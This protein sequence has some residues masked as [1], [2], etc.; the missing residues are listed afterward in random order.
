MR[1]VGKNKMNI[2]SRDKIN[3]IILIY[4]PGGNLNK[5]LNSYKISHHDFKG[6]YFIL[7]RSNKHEVGNQ[8]RQSKEKNTFRKNGLMTVKLCKSKYVGNIEE[9]KMNC[10]G[11]Q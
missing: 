1:S 8:R 4:L 3:G 11:K 5:F 2:Y 7:Y 10:I 6:M 9:V